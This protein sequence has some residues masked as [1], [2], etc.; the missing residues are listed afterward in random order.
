MEALLAGEVGERIVE[1]EVGLLDLTQLVVDDHLRRHVNTMKSFFKRV[2]AIG[3]ESSLKLVILTKTIDN[4][5][6][7]RFFR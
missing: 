7:N 1:V 4:R 6:N 3:H 5:L 2:D